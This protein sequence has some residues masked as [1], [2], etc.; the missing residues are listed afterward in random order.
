MVLSLSV[1]VSARRV[2]GSTVGLVCVQH[3]HQLI[4]GKSS[5]ALFYISTYFYDEEVDGEPVAR[6]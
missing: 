4:D 3:H 5:F 2:V 1:L 6:T